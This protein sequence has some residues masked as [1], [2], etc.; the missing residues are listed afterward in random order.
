MAVA[1]AAGATVVAAGAVIDRSG[2][3]SALGV[4]F[5]ALVALALPTYDPAGCPMCQAG[6][7]I[8]KPGSRN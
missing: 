6:S 3:A 1:Q 7:P 8:A 2:G 4:P 5:S